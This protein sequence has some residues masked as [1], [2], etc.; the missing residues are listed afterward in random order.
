MGLINPEELYLLTYISSFLTGSAA[1]TVNKGNSGTRKRE[2]ER[3]RQVEVEV[4]C[5]LARTCR[6][7]MLLE[8]GHH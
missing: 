1:V 5:L 2:R 6:A 4:T 3:D 8:Q 7:Q